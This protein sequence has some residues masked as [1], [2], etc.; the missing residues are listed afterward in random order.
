M[1][2][3]AIL[4]ELK[5]TLAENISTHMRASKEVAD[6][7]AMISKTQ[8][9]IAALEG[10]NLAPDYAELTPW[11]E[12]PWAKEIDNPA[13]SVI[14]TTNHSITTVAEP[15]F[16]YDADGVLRPNGWVNVV[17]TEAAIPAFTL[18][19]LPTEDFADAGDL[20]GLRG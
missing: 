14:R 12:H 15:G 9:A 10:K 16:F 5:A 20:L 1:S 18:P 3:E 8:D 4:E 6:S 2:V 13:P 7:L 11:S 19:A 17:E